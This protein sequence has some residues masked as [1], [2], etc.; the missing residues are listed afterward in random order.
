MTQIPESEVFL[1]ESDSE[2][3]EIYASIHYQNFLT[4]K[5]LNLLETDGTNN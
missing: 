4:L 3:E 2:D 5:L 1:P